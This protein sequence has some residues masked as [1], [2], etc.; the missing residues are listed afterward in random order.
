MAMRYSQD[1]LWMRT[2]LKRGC[3]LSVL[4]DLRFLKTCA[5]I[6]HLSFCIC[7]TSADVDDYLG[8]KI[9]IIPHLISIHSI[10]EI[11]RF[12][13]KGT[14]P[15]VPYTDRQLTKHWPW[16]DWPEP[17]FFIDTISAL[18]YFGLLA[19]HLAVKKLFLYNNII[20]HV[21]DGARRMSRIVYST[22]H[23]ISA[24]ALY[25]FPVFTNSRVCDFQTIGQQ[26]ISELKDSIDCNKRLTGQGKNKNELLLKIYTTSRHPTITT[27]LVFT[28][29][30]LLI[31][32]VKLQI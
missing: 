3:Y 8:K 18:F 9:K 22:L 17:F 30:N 27:N 4:L 13:T 6:S 11:S 28:N 12:N 23:K 15:I 29:H 25:R 7:P 20:L 32:S 26:F 10:W 21:Q 1:L 24:H 31:K 19:N 14:V 2:P 5:L 16:I